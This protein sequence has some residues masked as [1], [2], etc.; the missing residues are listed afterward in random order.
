MD[1]LT[2]IL[3]EFN[4]YKGQL[5]IIGYS[6]IER[7]IAI[8]DDNSDYY[9]V[10]WDGKSDKLNWSTCVGP[11]IPLKGFLRD[12]DYETLKS[13][14]ILNHWDTMSGIHE[15]TVIKIKNN[16]IEYWLQ[17]EDHKF[18]TETCWNLN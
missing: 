17:N 13:I 12:K 7:L 10:T 6:N 3:E 4:Q 8:G 5:V 11:L 14:A 18:I 2:K 9:Y 16:L 15:D 1:N